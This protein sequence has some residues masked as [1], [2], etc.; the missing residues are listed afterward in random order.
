[1]R[2]TALVTEVVGAAV[3]GPPFDSRGGAVYL[4]P[5]WGFGALRLSPMTGPGWHRMC[6]M[7]ARARMA[8]TSRKGATRM[9]TSTAVEEAV[10]ASL[11]DEP[12]LD[13]SS[14]AIRI[15]FE[16]GTG[17]L[18]MEGEV[19]DIAAKKLALERAAAHPEVLG[20][21]DRL[22][23][24]PAVVQDDATVRELVLHA[25]IQEPAFADL[26]LFERL[27]GRLDPVHVPDGARGRIEVDVSDGVVT[28]DGSVPGLDRK[29]LAGV[30]AWWVP[31]SRDVVDGIGVDPPEEDDDGAI[32]DAV[33]LVLEKDPFLDAVRVGINVRD[34]VVTLTG[35]LATEWQRNM[36][37]FDAWYIFA[38][39]RVVNLIEVPS[40][41][42][43]A[44]ED[45]EAEA[46]W[47]VIEIA[48]GHTGGD[49]RRIVV[50]DHEVEEDAVAAAM[51]ARDAREVALEGEIA[52]RWAVEHMGREIDLEEAV[53]RYEAE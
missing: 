38:V 47:R 1:M 31:G 4:Q 13:D 52:V 22:H 34:A 32:A 36:A 18:V 49:E 40:E 39:D 37:E 12:R 33:R 53:E 21:V 23:T 8:G 5:A 19:S 46:E 28:L 44:G 48:Q 17:A 42:A 3:G 35:S 11:G 2:A 24:R 50:S 9:T 30:L 6:P 15:S 16:E 20:I 27:D 41:P 25:F 10:R 26:A 7:P 14:R 43:G 45:P 29:R 51:A